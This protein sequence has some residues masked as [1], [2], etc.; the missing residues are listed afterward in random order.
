M[1]AQIITIRY[2]L[3]ILHNFCECKSQ[4]MYI[5]TGLNGTKM[6][7]EVWYRT[8]LMDTDKYKKITF[9]YSNLN[10]HNSIKQMPLVSHPIQPILDGHIIS[11]RPIKK[12]AENNS[13]MWWQSFKCYNFNKIVHK[14]SL[15]PT[16]QHI[17]WNSPD[18]NVILN[19]SEIIKDS[20]R[21][22]HPNL[23]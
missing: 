15:W 12:C 17:V 20:E 21:Y 8:L 1:S 16:K 7:V 11:R 9:M 2:Y 18:F 3:C 5:S 19:W 23:Q 22:C 10:Q 14:Y 13:Y 6:L 4:L